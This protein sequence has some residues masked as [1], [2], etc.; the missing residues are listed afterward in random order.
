[1]SRVAEVA[2]EAKGRFARARQDHPALDH[3]VRMQTH[4]GD[5]KASQQAGGVT[6]FA[7]LSVFPVLA[8]AFFVVGLVARVY[9][10][11]QQNLVDGINQV[12]PGLV[13]N[14][15]G[16]ISLSTIQDSAG[17]IGLIGLVAVIYSGTG[18]VS[19][20]RQALVIVFE[21]PENEQLNFVFGKLRDVLTLALIGTVLI[22]SVAISGVVASLS[23]T[24]LGLIGLA[25]TF[26]WLV[27][28]ISIVLGLAANA[29]LFFA[30]FRV[31]ANPPLPSRA[32]WSGAALGAVAFEILKQLSSL[33][34]ASTKNQP[35]FQA[36]GIALILVVWINYFSRVVLYAA[37][38]AYTDPDATAER[39]KDEAQ[40]LADE[41]QERTRFIAPSEPEGLSPA[42]TFAAGA[43][44]AVALVGVVRRRSR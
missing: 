24:L 4:Y 27:S 15:S 43:A 8:L 17:A 18:W 9:P 22:A 10:D 28:L 41:E 11:A 2:D 32:L 29:L 33:L 25:D 26:A 42:A 16:Q 31:L 3:A 14:G 5:T 13:G 35:A 36:F 40:R 37:S 12:L 44:A 6:Y 34:L 30:M 20:L 19:S 7:F 39:E 1:M 21:L 38:W 23:G